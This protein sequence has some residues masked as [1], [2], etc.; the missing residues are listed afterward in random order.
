MNPE[1]VAWGLI[2]QIFYFDILTAFCTKALILFIN[3]K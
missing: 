3:N 2:G 1:D